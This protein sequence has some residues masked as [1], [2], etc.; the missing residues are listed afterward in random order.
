MTTMPFTRSGAYGQIA[1]CRKKYL[2]RL[3]HPHHKTQAQN[4]PV[5]Y[6]MGKGLPDRLFEG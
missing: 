4:V 5:F 2:Y 6:K 3:D 1:R